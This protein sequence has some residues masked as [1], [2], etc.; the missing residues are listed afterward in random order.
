MPPKKKQKQK[1]TAG[2]ADTIRT[3]DR[4][5]ATS[6][7]IKAAGYKLANVDGGGN[8]F[9]FS[10]V[11]VL[12]QARFK[13]SADI[14]DEAVTAVH[15]LESYFSDEKLMSML[16]PGYDTLSHVG[17][18]TLVAWV[19][20]YSNLNIGK[21][22]RRRLLEFHTEGTLELLTGLEFVSDTVLYG[23]LGFAK[24]FDRDALAGGLMNNERY[25]DDNDLEVIRCLLPVRLWIVS[26]NNTVN[27]LGPTASNN[28]IHGAEGPVA[29]FARRMLQYGTVPHYQPICTG[30]CLYT[31]AEARDMLREMN[32][33]L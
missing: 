13:G 26:E 9:Y 10:I 8:C 33:T 19:I 30:A 22:I 31:E 6:T 20:A 17:L 18:R 7:R 2:G 1:A 12:R 25:A 23:D 15:I 29:L 24:D 28:C 5:Y 4:G 32:I 3:A 21:T 16:A 11:E 27:N 14:E